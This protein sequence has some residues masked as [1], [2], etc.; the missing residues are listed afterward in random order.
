MSELLIKPNRKKLIIPRPLPHI[1]G[2]PLHMDELRLPPSELDPEDPFSR[3]NNHMH[4]YK[5]RYLGSLL[6]KT[7]MNLDRSQEQV[8]IDTHVI[9]HQTYSPAPLP[10]PHRAMQVIDDEYHSGGMLRY[11]SANNPIYEPITQELYRQVVSEYE[12]LR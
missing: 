6:F 4:W 11:G 8:P 12:A 7:L 2:F 10:R 3:N 5:R 9:Y 1:D